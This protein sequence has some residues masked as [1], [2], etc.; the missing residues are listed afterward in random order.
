MLL[1]KEGLQGEELQQLADYLKNHEKPD[2][3]HLSNALL[4]GMAA[5]IK[6]I[7]G[8]PVVCSLQDEDVWVDAMDPEKQDNMWRLMSEK[9]KDADAFIAVSRYFASFMQMKMDI[10]DEK[11]HVV[12]IGVDPGKYSVHPATD[13][14]PA[15]GYL[16]RIC[17]DNGFGIVVD[18]FINLKRDNRFSELRLHVTGGMTG[19]DRQ[20][21]QE[22]M[23][24]VGKHGLSGSVRLFNEFD[25]V[26]LEKFFRS[27]TLLSV[28]V[29]RGEAFGLYQIEAMASGVPLVQPALGAFPEIAEATGGSFIYHPNTAGALTEALSGILSDPDRLQ[30]MRT[31]GRQ[32]VEEKFNS[33]LLAWQ[34]LGIYQQILHDRIFRQPR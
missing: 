33:Q 18:A 3:V 1:G 23:K 29:L 20:F 8:V 30:Q 17:A 22:Q 25:P 7:A 13:G 34:M 21:F 32:A 16:S 2:V 4:L 27:V 31:A 19:D 24:K 15:I 26:S 5:G 9:G 11:M 14:P 6:E 28:P 10:P 12:P